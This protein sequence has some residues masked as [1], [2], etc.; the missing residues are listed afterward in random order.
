[1]D[2][3]LGY[4]A[5]QGHK[6]VVVIEIEEAYTKRRHCISVKSFF[7]L[8][9]E[10]QFRIEEISRTLPYPQRNFKSTPSGVPVSPV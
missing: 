3:Q 2:L 6:M 1:M 4:A 10:R 9:L 7:V 5:Y 8:A